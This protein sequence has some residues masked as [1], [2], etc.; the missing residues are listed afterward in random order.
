MSAPLGFGRRIIDCAAN[1]T[2]KLRRRAKLRLSKLKMSAELAPARE[3][4]ARGFMRGGQVMVMVA[5]LLVWPRLSL[6]ADSAAPTREMAIP[7][8]QQIVGTWQLVSIYEEN[9]GGEDIDQFGIAPQGQF[10][11]DGRGRF[12]FQIFSQSGRRYSSR[13]RF[14]SSHRAALV[15]AI[16]YFGAYFYDSKNNKLILHASHCLFRSCDKSERISSVK[17]VG[18][19]LKMESAATLSPTG[20]YY[21]HTIWRRM[22]CI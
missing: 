3:C 20:A 7:S 8:A 16:T 5:A 15:E 22:C 11:A 10:I 6:Y 21:S 18:N 19:E 17:I 1:V 2:G 9:A 12:S 4:R 13:D 14:T